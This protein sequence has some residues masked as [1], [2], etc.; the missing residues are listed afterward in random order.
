MS[1]MADVRPAWVEIDLDAVTN[2][3]KAVRK[4]LKDETKIMA[5]VKGDAYGCASAL[6]AQMLLELGAD[7][8]AVAILDEALELRKAGIEDPILVLGYTP[9]SQAK[10]AVK[11]DITLTVYRKESVEA[12]SKAA[13]ELKKIG[14]VHIK[15][16][17]GMGRIGLQP[18]QEVVKFIKEAK[19]LDKIETEGIYTH[20]SVA[21]MEEPGDKEYTYD[22]L[23]IFEET[24]SMLQKEEMEVP[25]KHACNSAAIMN[26]PESRLDMV[27]T[28]S[29]IFG[30]TVT[31]EINRKLDLRP[32]ISLKASIGHVKKVPKGRA[33]SYGRT[34][35]TEKETT[36]ATLPLGYADGYSRLLSN[37]SQVL[38]GGKKNPQIGL[39]CM[40]QCMVDVSEVEPTPQV[41]DTAVLL[42][43]QGEEEITM[44]DLARIMGAKAN[45]LEVVTHFTKRLPRVYIWQGEPIAVYDMN[46]LRKKQ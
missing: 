21:E 12:V 27:R 43:R 42:G 41:N 22:Q 10:L 31:D 23:S 40:D 25:I 18:G 24:L 6:P 8:L 16:D 26:I 5:V 9:A 46:G 4:T 7:Y 39:V 13:Q 19:N 3:Y 30:I 36:I 34:Y 11:N 2:N 29:A 15:V 37:Q 20:F 14:K 45:D 35:V 32:V 28:G 1:V 33:I 17:T 44:G 38:V